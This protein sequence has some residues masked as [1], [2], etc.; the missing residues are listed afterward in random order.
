MLQCFTCVKYFLVRHLQGHHLAGPRPRLRRSEAIKPIN[1]PPRNPTRH[2]P[3][4]Q[5][6]KQ[7]HL[8]CLRD[9]MRS[10]REFRAARNPSTGWVRVLACRQWRYIHTTMAEP[11]LR[12]CGRMEPPLGHCNSSVNPCRL[13]NRVF[14]TDA[15][16]LG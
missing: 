16:L 8:G 3:A 15:T 1:K 2:V 13:N 4:W 9:E 7:T 12:V 6:S 14:S 11:P 10:L 5:C